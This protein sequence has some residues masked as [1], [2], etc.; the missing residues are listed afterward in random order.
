MVAKVASGKQDIEKSE[1]Q[2]GLKEKPKKG[3]DNA[4][5]PQ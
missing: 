1:K 4:L 3:Q 2:T 5:K